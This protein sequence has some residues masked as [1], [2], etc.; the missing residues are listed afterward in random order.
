VSDTQDELR[1]EAHAE[2]IRARM[3]R[4]THGPDC[5]CETDEEETT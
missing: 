1:A 3:A 2:R 4:C 5:I